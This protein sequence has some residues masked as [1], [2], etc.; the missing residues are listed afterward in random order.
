MRKKKKGF[1]K[2][3]AGKKELRKL[4]LNYFLKYP[5]KYFNHK[6][7]GSALELI[8][9]HQ[10][11]QLIQELYK[12]VMDGFLQEIEK[13]RFRLTHRDEH[14]VGTIDFTRLGSA[15]LITADESKDILIPK[16]KSL[17]ALH[18]DTVKV[19]LKRI[20]SGRSEGEVV[21]VIKR[22]KN[23][24]VGIFQKPP[25]QKFGFVVP[26]NQKNPSDFFIAEKDF[27]GAKD[28]QMVLM[29]F[30]E[31]EVGSPSPKG[32]IIEILGNPGETNTEVHAILADYGLPYKFP[33]EVEAFA[34]RLTMNVEEELD[35]RRDFRT[36]TTFTIDPRDAKDFDDAISVK[37]L[38]NG[39]F[40]IGV[41][42]ADVSYFV[43]EDSILDEEAYKRGTSVYLVDRVVPMLPEALSN[44]LCS[45]KPNEDRFAFSA[46][47]ELN[48]YGKVF[49]EWYGR[50]IIHSDRRFTYEEAQKIIETGEGDLSDEIL[51][52]HEIATHLRRNRLKNGAIAFDRM[53]LKFHLDEQHNPIGVYFKQAKE[54]NHLI[55][56]FMLLANRKVSEFVS[57]KKD[58]TPTARTFI[59]RIHDDPDPEK[60][61]ALK[62]FV[63]SFG[64]FLDISNRKRITRSLNEML[65]AVKG[66]G[67]E[68]MIENLTL[69]TM[70]KAVYSTHN[71]GHYGLAFDYYT[72]FTSPI[73]RYPDLMAHRLLHHYLMGGKSPNA[74]KYEVKCKHCSK[75][76]RQAADAERD[77]IK[78]MQVKYL[79]KFQG[80]EFEGVISGVTDRG[81]FVEIT[82]NHCEGMIKWRDLV[83]DSYYYDGAQHAIIGRKLGR[84]F[85][86]GQKLRIKVDK[87][88][89]EKKQADFV[90]VE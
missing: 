68:M 12:M 75:R 3:K 71:I 20:S 25:Q 69:R 79:E 39:N 28:G 77:S 81:L 60:L 33:E 90:L 16:G 80:Q 13:G 50:T 70:S 2:S 51:I 27:G 43:P 78:F 14:I 66:K 24:F 10:R 65:A 54:A 64:Y 47:F 15:Y 40:E 42:I 7:L 73:R 26:Q 48:S 56:E 31:W 19:R 5:N 38:E 82:E 41:H 72:H 6:Q 8:H 1:K 85:Q 53:E 52:C 34:E 84:V 46:V 44:D 11:E 55:E 17:N 4:I 62:E 61:N 37:K 35:K 89:V 32:K 49:N 88:N 67:E 36:V 21:E 59:Y 86:L 9:P 83:D 87:V 23:R 76:E 57:I 30:L 18:G 29:E 58:G 22:N 45:L 63:E 74:E